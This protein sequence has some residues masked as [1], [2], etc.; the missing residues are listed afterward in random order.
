MGI[1]VGEF[2]GSETHV[3]TIKLILYMTKLYCIFKNTQ[4][5]AIILV[6]LSFSDTKR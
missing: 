2:R 6:V 1:V 4:L 3:F 5:Y